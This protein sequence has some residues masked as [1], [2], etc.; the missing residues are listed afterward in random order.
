MPGVLCDNQCKN[1]LVLKKLSGSPTFLLFILGNKLRDE[2]Y[3]EFDLTM[4]HVIVIYEQK[5]RNE[6]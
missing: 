5:T 3:E 4:G 6:G 2:I 1:I